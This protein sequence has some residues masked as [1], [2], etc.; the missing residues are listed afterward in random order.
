MPQP[1][2]F[3]VE[4]PTYIGVHFGVEV[5][6]VL[7]G[8]WRGGLLLLCAA[9]VSCPSLFVAGSGALL[10]VALFT[11]THC[12]HAVCLCVCVC[13][14][15]WQQSAVCCC[16]VYCPLHCMACSLY[17]CVCCVCACIWMAAERCVLLPCL[18]P[19][20]AWHGVCMCV[21]VCVC[22]RVCVC[23]CVWMAAEHC[24]LLPCLLPS[25]A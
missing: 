6:V 11:A 16:P 24:L 5:K 15:G 3:R 20:T 9:A 1:A 21:C 18:P 12:M 4:G 2:R 7:W 17:V 19:S 23:A 10:A 22:V 8:F 14:F 13:V 25:T